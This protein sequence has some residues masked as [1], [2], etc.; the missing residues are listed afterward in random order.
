MAL[1]RTVDQVAAKHG[2]LL[3]GTQVHCDV[4]RCVAWRRFKPYVVVQCEVTGNSLY[5]PSVDHRQH[6]VLECLASC[7]EATILVESG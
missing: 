4:P 5:L 6:T 1:Q 2:A 7:R 3:A